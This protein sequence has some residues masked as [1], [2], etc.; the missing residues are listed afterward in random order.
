MQRI[1]AL[2][3][4]A[5]PYGDVDVMTS[6]VLASL[7]IHH[8]PI[9]WYHAILFLCGN[10]MYRMKGNKS[11]LCGKTKSLHK[12]IHGGISIIGSKSPPVLAARQHFLPRPSWRSTLS[13][14][15]VA[16]QEASWQRFNQWRLRNVSWSLVN[17][18]RRSNAK[19]PCVGSFAN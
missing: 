12:V 2:I 8:Q 10:N 18:V 6:T 7:K 15:S 1:W 4:P 17:N 13:L 14:Q 3:N 19:S 16:L 5:A 9:R 11:I